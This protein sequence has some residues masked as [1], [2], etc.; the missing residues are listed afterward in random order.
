MANE[1]SS[2]IDS[3][4]PITI[5][6]DV[7][8]KLSTNLKLK[9]TKY[10]VYIKPNIFNIILTFIAFL[11][12]L[13][14]TKKLGVSVLIAVISYLGF[15]LLLHPL[16]KSKFGEKIN[17]QSFGRR[18][19][20]IAPISTTSQKVILTS[21]NKHL[22]ALAVLQLEWSTGQI[23]LISLWDYFE[24]ENIQIQDCKEGCFLVIKKKVEIKKI[25]NIQDQ[26]T[27][28]MSEIEKTV[29][30]TIKKF[31]LEFDFMQIKIV[32]GQ[33][34]ILEILNLGLAPEKFTT[35]EEMSEEDFESL[36]KEIPNMVREV[37]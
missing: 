33:K 19:N 27:K 26:V 13:L 8:N 25:G 21:L 34:K 7:S 1:N 6:N 35:F 16:L 18:T 36:R 2:L 10:L 11:L 5:N 17:M 15:S 3:Q 32:K 37:T 29:L 12:S 9:L 14:A 20:R 30:L 31:E 28:L 24:S 22:I 4:Q 23:P